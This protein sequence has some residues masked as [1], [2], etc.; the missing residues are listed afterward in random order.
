VNPLT[1]G[2]AAPLADEAWLRR[3]IERAGQP[4]PAG[5]REAL[6]AARMTPEEVA[7]FQAELRRLLEG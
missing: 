7:S 5:E 1:A 3:D 2:C 6:R 4:D